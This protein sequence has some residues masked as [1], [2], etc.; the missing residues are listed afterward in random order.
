MSKKTIIV[1]GA[2]LLLAVPVLLALAD[3]ED[4]EQREVG[5]V[6]CTAISHLNTPQWTAKY[7]YMSGWG[8]SEAESPIDRIGLTSELSVNGEPLGTAED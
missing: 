8:R 4:R 2:L 5:G 3:V 1:V 7:W 6:L